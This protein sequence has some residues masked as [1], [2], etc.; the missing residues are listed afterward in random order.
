MKNIWMADREESN[1][2][3]TLMYLVWYLKYHPLNINGNELNN[4]PRNAS[5]IKWF[6]YHYWCWL[7][8]IKVWG[9]CYQK[10]KKKTNGSSQ[11]YHDRNRSKWRM[12]V[13]KVIVGR[14]TRTAVDFYIALCLSLFHFLSA[15]CRNT[16][17]LFLCGRYHINDSRLSGYNTALPY[18]QLYQTDS[19]PSFELRR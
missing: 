9:L 5:G 16:M 3:A 13:N 17:I 7:M 4:D 19:A 6:H 11:W 1:R 8:G 15:L 10:K 18:I 12:E 14:M 2:R